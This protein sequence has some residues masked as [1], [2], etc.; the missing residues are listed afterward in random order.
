MYHPGYVWITPGWYGDGW[1]R[2]D[3]APGGSINCTD[4]EM[5]RVL[6]RSL[7]V[8]QYPI[9]DREAITASGIVSAYTHTI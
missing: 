1:W 4:R 5:Q 9:V 7:A 3:E 6:D 8:L 2:S